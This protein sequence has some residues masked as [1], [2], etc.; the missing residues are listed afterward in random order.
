MIVFNGRRWSVTI[1][2]ITA[3]EGNGTGDSLRHFPLS[4]QDYVLADR[5]YCQARGMHFAARHQAYVT[6]RLKAQGIGLQ[7]AAGP[8]LPYVMALTTLPEQ[9]F[10]AG[11][12]LEWYR[13]RWQIELVFKRFK[14]IARL[15]HLPQDDEESAKAWRYGKL[16]V[17]L[18]TEKLIRHASAVSPWGYRLEL[19]T[20]LAAGGVSFPSPFINSPRPSNRALSLRRMIE[21]WQSIASNLTEPPRKRTLQEET[22]FETL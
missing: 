21:N 7:A 22:F 2:K 3:T 8:E 13:F 16:F 19:A 17:A 4:P 14:Q 9:A 1:V 20:L 11:L 5:G 15:G 12:I 10:P 6:V 18:L